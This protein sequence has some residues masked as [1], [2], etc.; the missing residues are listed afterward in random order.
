MRRTSSLRALTSTGPTQEA[1]YVGHGSVDWIQF[2]PRNAFDPH[3]RFLNAWHQLLLLALV[4]EAVVLPFTVAFTRTETSPLYQRAEFQVLY[5][6]ESLFVVDVYVKLHTGF[7]ENGNIHRDASKAR[8]KYLLSPAFLADAV[9]LVPFG[10][11]GVELP[12]PTA[13]RAWL[14][15]HKLVRLWRVPSYY[16]TLEDLYAKYFVTHKMIKV[17]ASTAF[18][19]HVLTCA[20]FSFGYAGES[21]TWLASPLTNSANSSSTQYL[22]AITWTFGLLTGVLEGARPRTTDEFVFTLAVM[23]AGLVLATYLCAVFFVLAKSEQSQAAAIADARIEQLKH[24][25]SYHHVPEHLQLQAVEYIQ[26]YY[27]DAESND[28]QVL[29]MLCP[30]I[31]KDIQVELLRDTV[32]TIPLFKSCHPQFIVA[33][34][35]LLEMISLPADFVLFAAGDPGD[36]MYVVNSGVLH[37]I[38]NDIKMRELRSGSFFGEVSVFAKRPRSA[39]VVTTSY[40]TLY[41]LSRFHVERVLE[42]YPQYAEVI[43][44]AVESIVKQQQAANHEAQVAAAARAAPKPPPAASNGGEETSE[45]SAPT[46]SPAPATTGLE[47]FALTTLYRVSHEANPAA[48]ENYIQRRRQ[49]LKRTSPGKKKRP[50]LGR[51][52]SAQNVSIARREELSMLSRR[53]MN[54]HT[55]TGE[56]SGETVAAEAMPRTT[57]FVPSPPR[58]KRSQTFIFGRKVP[59]LTL[60]TPAWLART[61]SSQQANSPRRSEARTAHGTL[62]YDNAS[63]AF[64]PLISPERPPLWTKLLL[65]ECIRRGSRFRLVW[66]V[67]LQVVL[68]YHLVLLPLQLGFPLLRNATWYVQTLNALLDIV[69]VVDLYVNLHLEPPVAKKPTPRHTARAY[70]LSPACLADVL[71]VFPYWI[72]APHFMPSAVLRLPRYLRVWRVFDHTTEWHSTRPTIVV[73]ETA[74]APQRRQASAFRTRIQRFI[75]LLGLLA[76]ALHLLAC[77]YFGLTELDGFGSDLLDMDSARSA[78]PYLV[79]RQYFWS[80]YVAATLLTTLGRPPEPQTPRQFVFTLVCMLLGL[81]WTTT[82]IILVQKRFTTASQEQKEFLTTRARI[83]AFLHS[84]NAPLPILTRVNA[85]L[86]FWWS[87]HRGAIVGELLNELPETIKRQIVQEMCKPA[88]QTL[89]LLADVR[90]VLDDLERVFVD[91]VQFI[92]Y[93]QGE[94]I[95][96]EGDYASGLFFLLEGDVCMIA[97]G[98]EP[99]IVPR[100]SFFGTA[101]LHLTETSV[102]YAERMTAISGC[103]LVYVAREHLHAM[104]KTFPTLSMALKALEKRIRNTKSAARAHALGSARRSSTGTHSFT[105]LDPGKL[106]QQKKT[107]LAR[108]FHVDTDAQV[109]FDPDAP[110]S[111]A[112][113]LWILVLVTVQSFKVI[114]EVCF[115]ITSRAWIIQSELLTAVLEL[116]FAMDV[117]FQ[118][119]LGVYEYGNKILDV[120]QLRQRYFHSQRF[121]LDVVALVPLFIINW[122][123]GLRGRVELLNVHKLVRLLKATRALSAWETQYLNRTLELRVVKLVYW[124]LLLSH[125]LGCVWFSFGFSPSGSSWLASEQVLGSSSRKHQYLASLYWSFGLMSASTAGERPE[126]ALQSAFTVLTLISGLLLTAYAIGNLTDV[127]ELMGADTREFNRRLSALRH[128]L[129]HFKLPATLEDKLKTYSFF[130]RFHSITQEHVLERCLPPSLLTDIRLVHLQPMMVQVAF[131]AGMEASVT[132]MLVAQFVQVLIVKDEFVCRYGEEGTDMFFVFTGVLDVMVPASSLHRLSSDVPATSGLMAAVINKSAGGGF[133]SPPQMTMKK[134]NELRSGSYFGEIALFGNRV[135]SAH[136]LARTSCVLYRLSRRALELVFERYPDWKKN[137]LKIVSIQQEQQHLRTLYLA[138]QQHDASNAKQDSQ[139]STSATVTPVLIGRRRSAKPDDTIP[140]ASQFRQSARRLVRR[141]SNHKTPTGPSQAAQAKMEPPPEPAAPPTSTTRSTTASTLWIDTLLEC[142]HVQSPTHV[143]WLQT[144]VV[145]TT[146]MAISVPYRI[147]FHP[148]DDL[149]ALALTVHVLEHTCELLFAW[150]IWMN[151]N[152]KESL[153]SLELYEQR[154]RTAYTK[155][156][157]RWD[158]LAAI[159]IDHFLSDFYVS[160]WLRINRC[161]KVLN[162]ASYLEESQ[163]RS[164]RY[165]LTRLLSHWLLFSIAIYWCACAAHSLKTSHTSNA[166][167]SVVLHSI[168]FAATMFFKKGPTLSPLAAPSPQLS[169]TLLVAFLGLL[170]MALLIAEMANLY[171]SFISHEVDFRKHHLAVELYLERWRVSG[172]LRQRARAFLSSLWSSHRGVN[173]QAILDDIP[174]AIRCEV[175][176]HIAQMP[177]Q[178]FLATHFR[179]FCGEEEKELTALVSALAPQLKYEGYPRDENVLIEGSIMKEMYFV[180]SG[181]LVALKSG[182]AVA[183]STPTTPP[184][185]MDHATRRASLVRFQGGDYFG[186]KGL[187]GYSVSESTV[188][189]VR[190]CDLLSLSSEALLHA[191]LGRPLFQTALSLAAECYREMAVNPVHTG[192]GNDEAWG[193]LLLLVIAR[194][195]RHWD[196]L[197]EAGHQSHAMRKTLA[198]LRTLARPEDCLRVFENLLRLIVPHGSL[199][200]NRRSSSFNSVSSHMFQDTLPVMHAT[201]LAPLL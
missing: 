190:A 117:I 141:I 55:T 194:R 101:A 127:V 128:L 1:R 182:N 124:T 192:A 47:D 20:R 152:L 173:Y 72:F 119:R 33:I 132:R 10:L 149:S 160:P 67:V 23:L 113:E 125:T 79:A 29:K 24:L 110:S 161:L 121:V 2:D 146:F 43:A 169:F 36:C 74:T 120:P 131:L 163:R 60:Q 185:V 80:V 8:I 104:H 136:T 133:A 40:C 157:L 88:I 42:G 49:T 68:L 171:V 16:A 165:A 73:T 17:L 191:L 81:L 96:R 184:V 177:L 130:Q 69:L 145:A 31:A 15:C 54:E 98:G 142:T 123:L 51:S 28:R 34:T 200:W 94:T 129:T 193:A 89:S 4:Y 148:L 59:P 135:R 201:T 176:Q 99:R 109:V 83:Q 111:S 95:Y 118:S 164:V 126:T 3:S 116:F 18:L 45:S 196:Q 174:L 168:F 58:V 114:Y 107:L 198:P 52:K 32:A 44:R 139:P 14:E 19:A 37:I 166:S 197:Y 179:A 155:T 5:A 11:L 158:A 100:G 6:L 147:A 97:H 27:T 105:G 153:A 35:S 85:F 188:K 93:G 150:D 154:H 25:L 12:I 137:V 9:A 143:R 115:G 65:P 56:Q 178:R 46:P 86:D 21:D 187:L 162:L 7:Y 61:A 167:A 63:G 181:R 70:V 78:A 77:V 75:V 183:G 108:I 39:T 140:S 76:L 26:R 199:Q 13:S 122:G 53:S 175:V 189:T 144:M 90:P 151:W 180:V 64:L 156:R 159:P 71:A 84:Q 62:I 50:V 87:A 92:L 82:L 103:I 22:Q 170:I 38:V 186:E 41:K 91:N 195:Q 48:Q 57:T 172:T 102:S 134:V 112:W 106:K 30:S 66:L 138:E